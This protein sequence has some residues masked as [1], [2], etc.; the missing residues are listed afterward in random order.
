M[1]NKTL[2]WL[3]RTLQTFI[4]F[5][6]FLSP[7][8]QIVRTFRQEPYPY[9]R[10]PAV[11]VELSRDFLIKSDHAIRNYLDPFYENLSGG[12]Y[13]L[14]VFPVIFTEPL[15]VAVRAV[16]S[17]LH[18]SSWNY[19]FILTLIIAI[20]LAVFFG[21]VYCGYICPMSLLTAFNLKIQKKLFGRKIHAQPPVK[22]RFKRK[23]QV[24]FIAVL[25]ILIVTNPLIL[26]Y[27]L[28]PALFQHAVSDFFLWGGFTLWGA[29]SLG[30]IVFEASKPGHFCRYLC[31]TGTFLSF[32]GKKKFFHLQHDRNRECPK[33]CTLCLDECWLG[34]APK[35]RIEDP[36]CDLCSRCLERCPTNR[37]KFAAFVLLCFLLILPAENSLAGS[38]QHTDSYKDEINI[39]TF[40]E[41]ET[42]V[43][44]KN[45][46][47]LKVFY[48][49]FGKAS[50]EHKPGT[51]SLFIHIQQGDE[52]Y[53]RPLV[54]TLFYKGQ[55]VKKENF[56]GVTHPISIIK[57]S[58]Y[59]MEFNYTPNHKYK[60]V[61]DSPA[62]DFD[63]LTISF[64]HPPIRF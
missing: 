50:L 10:S 53:S 47:T 48:S 61:I 51:L 44:C 28:P 33:G 46:E 14:K 15:T 31:P 26:Q 3:R 20:G 40:F 59:G 39:K 45:G 23:G 18:P 4:I 5:M 29:L 19:V 8:F 62:N 63:P 54:I 43:K 36:R 27:I 41:G 55:A 57:R 6:L 1:P 35:T 32:V 37:I 38:W 12:P 64:R 58:T 22:S 2:P 21:R 52:I 34:L 56:A 13:T 42:T 24:V 60:F 16:N 49:I 7:L 30:V 9:P 17:V 11:N 25:V